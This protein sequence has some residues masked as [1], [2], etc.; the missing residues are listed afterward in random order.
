M[1]NPLPL[2]THIVATLLRK[3]IRNLP[4]KQLALNPVNPLLLNPDSAN[5]P[6]KP[7][8]PKPWFRIVQ[9]LEPLNAE[10]QTL[11]PQ[12]LAASAQSSQT[13][14]ELYKP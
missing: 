4:W 8:N 10:N 2:P 13:Q 1:T 14:L 12:G 3:S 11:V 7:Q 5:Q 9:D 6:Y